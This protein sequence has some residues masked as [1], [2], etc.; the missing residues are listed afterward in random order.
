MRVSIKRHINQ[1]FIDAVEYVV[2]NNLDCNKSRIA[3]ELKI[4]PSRFSEILNKRMNVGTDIIAT[5]CN[6]FNISSD[7]ILTGNGEMTNHNLK[8]IENVILIKSLQDLIDLQRKE[9]ERLKDEIV[10]LKK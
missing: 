5:F 6:Y 3:S 10:E 2:S 9:I 4:S 8:N 1:R 7:W